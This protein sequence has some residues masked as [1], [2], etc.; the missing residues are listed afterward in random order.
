MNFIC[1][2]LFGWT[3]PADWEIVEYWRLFH[4]ILCRAMNLNLAMELIFFSSSF[5]FV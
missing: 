5:G 1:S 3:G 2:I 4:F